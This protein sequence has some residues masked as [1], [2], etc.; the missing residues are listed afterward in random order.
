MEAVKD[1]NSH[2]SFLLGIANKILKGG[3]SRFRMRSRLSYSQGDAPASMLPNLISMIYARQRGLEGRDLA[4][5]AFLEVTD[6]QNP[7]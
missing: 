1:Y 7:K 5:N 6:H 2:L 3:I 4:T